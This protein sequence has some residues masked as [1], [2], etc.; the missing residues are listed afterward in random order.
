[1]R[2]EVHHGSEPRGTSPSMLLTTAAAN[3]GLE[4]YGSSVENVYNLKVSPRCFLC[5]FY[6]HS[7]RA[8]YTFT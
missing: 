4:H 7:F 2:V 3:K 5:S 6:L 8:F 1:M